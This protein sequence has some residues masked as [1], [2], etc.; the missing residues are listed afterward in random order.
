MSDRARACGCNGTARADCGPC[1]RPSAPRAAPLRLS[2]P[3]AVRLDED[4]RRAAVGALAA[5]LAPYLDPPVGRGGHAGR[6]RR[7]VRRHRGDDP[8][9]AITTDSNQPASKEER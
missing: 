7:K 1:G 2:A 3:V 4:R 5:L 9:P 6:P 8:E